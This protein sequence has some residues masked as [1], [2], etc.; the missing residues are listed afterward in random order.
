MPH[1][2]GRFHALSILM[3][4]ADMR[5]RV[6]GPVQT[7][8]ADGHGFSAVM[9]RTEDLNGHECARNEVLASRQS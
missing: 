7:L 6:S 9:L 3:Q 8:R 2:R 1:G 4:A 5:W